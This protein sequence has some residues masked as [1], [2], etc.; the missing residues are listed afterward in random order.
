MTYLVR[1]IKLIIL[2]TQWK[3]QCCINWISTSELSNFDR[4]IKGGSMS[5]PLTLI[6]PSAT[7]L[8]TPTSWN[9]ALSLYGAWSCP[10][11]EYICYLLLFLYSSKFYDCKIQIRESFLPQTLTAVFLGIFH[12]TSTNE[13][14]LFYETC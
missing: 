4:E 5:E 13:H 6:L 14:N 12:I 7:L 2:E 9:T 8:I 3:L 11:K 10:T 1:Q